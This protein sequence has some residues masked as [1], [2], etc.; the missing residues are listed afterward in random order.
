MEKVTLDRRAFLRVTAQAGGG[1]L[2]ATY[3]EPAAGALGLADTAPFAPNAFIRISADGAITIIAKN[4][5]IGQG[6]KTMLPMLVAEELD[7]D[8]TRVTIEQADLD[9]A[10][11]GP[12]RAGG[13]TATPTTGIRF[14]GPAPP[15]V[16]CSWR[17]PPAGGTC[18]GASARPGRAASGTAPPGDRSATASLRPRRPHCRRRT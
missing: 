9:E 7:A 16:R 8:W 10:S 2:I 17:P 5:E 4:P 6:V 14:A 1:M 15:D 13:S 11:Y 18:R 3:I 12:Q